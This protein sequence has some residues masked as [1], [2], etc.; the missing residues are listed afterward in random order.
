M[1]TGI[2]V[3][4]PIKVSVN[5]SSQGK[6]FSAN[7]ADSQVSLCA[8]KHSFYVWGRPVLQVCFLTLAAATRSW[9]FTNC[10]KLHLGLLYRKLLLFIALKYFHYLIFGIL[11]NLVFKLIAVSFFS[12]CCDS[13]N[14][15]AATITG[16]SWRVLVTWRESI[17]QT[18]ERNRA[19]TA[20][21]AVAVSTVHQCNARSRCSV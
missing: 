9:R 18:E 16:F 7:V 3:C 5:S 20:F 12:V 13:F 6:M 17:N 4:R 10:G 11:S 21:D 2:Y 8:C 15:I 19:V 1:A 14:V